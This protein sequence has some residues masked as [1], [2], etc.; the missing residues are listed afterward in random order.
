MENI[1]LQW[2]IKCYNG[3]YSAGVRVTSYY[4]KL[5]LQFEVTAVILRRK[6]LQSLTEYFL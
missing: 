2:K 5:V 6:L 4:Y 1:A 3:K